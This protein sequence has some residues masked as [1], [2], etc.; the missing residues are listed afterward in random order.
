[1]SLSALTGEG[2]ES[3][4]EVVLN[5]TSE[6]A[7]PLEL[8]YQ[9]YAEAEARLGWLNV[10]GVLSSQQPFAVKNWITHFLRLLDSTLTSQ[11]AALAHV[12]IQAMT[13]ASMFKA[14]LTQSG[15]PIMWDWLPEAEKTAG[16]E[17]I[18][19]AR[20]HTTPAILEQAVRWSFA[21]ATP[22]PTFRYDFTHFECFSPAP[23][24]PTHRLV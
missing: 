7:R 19:N 1:M 16:V 9:R 14:S 21:E 8:D 10:S 5:K 13:P 11:N 22:A 23:P 4:L 17:F 20:V 15:D 2:L 12:K 6:F 3:W 24:R 18:L